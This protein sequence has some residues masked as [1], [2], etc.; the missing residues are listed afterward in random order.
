[1]HNQLGQLTQAVNDLL[2]EAKKQGASGAE[3]GISVDEGLSVAVRLG[4]TE[5]VEHTRDTGLGLSVYFGQHKGSASTNDFSPA[6][7]KETVTKACAIARYTSEDDCN[8]LADAELMAKTFPELD[9]YHPW[10]D[11]T[12]EKATALALECEQAGLDSHDKISNSEGAHIS[13][14]NACF[15][16]GNSHGFIG[17]YPTSRHS[18]S[19]SL[20]AQDGDSMQRDYWYTNGRKASDLEDAT[21]VGKKAGDRTAARLNAKQIKTGSYPVLFQAD[22]APSL[23]RALFG[24]IRGH[25]QY[26]KS[27]FLLDQL[28]EKLFPEWVHIHENPLVPGA[29]GS[30]PFDNE[31]VAT[32]AKDFI[33][34]GELVNYVLGSYSARKL[35]MTT[36]ANA[37]GVRNLSIDPGQHDFEALLK[38]MHNGVLITEMMGQG[39]NNVTGDYSRGASGFWV[40]NGQI[41]YPVEGITVAN[42]MKNMFKQ[43]ISVGNDQ[44]IPGS[45]KTGSWLIETM[46]VAGS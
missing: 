29:L 8:G 33:K 46:T 44:D 42:N 43:L 30:A 34:D 14:T 28:G 36:T 11:L 37:G 1:M 19:C 17:G 25:A 31:G 22:V 9:L 5:T 4:E 38:Q 21:S 12:V 16:Y 27:T 35:N 45:I 32:Y 24:A 26:R 6:A 18:L 2:N 3:A 13:S 23:L 10:S 7:I 15:V 40:E 39:V 41:Q 20:L